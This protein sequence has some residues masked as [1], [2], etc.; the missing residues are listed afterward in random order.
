MACV[1]DAT[2]E[3]P[4]P[5][6]SS[7]SEPDDG[8]PSSSSSSSNSRRRGSRRQQQQG[9]MPGWIGRLQ[10][11][12]VEGCRSIF[13]PGRLCRAQATLD[14]STASAE[15]LQQA[16]RGLAEALAA[17]Q[18][19]VTDLASLKAYCLASQLGSQVTAAELRHCLSEALPGSTAAAA[20]VPVVAVGR[21]AS[22][23][24]ACVLLE[25]L[26]HRHP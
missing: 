15:Q 8:Q 3:D 9:S 25:L 23:G 26:A 17:A 6:S 7:D 4:S 12:Q 5:P 10:E 21:D 11:R 22:G 24:S 1:V 20:V 16:A 13:S 18:L 19:S 2:A 14:G